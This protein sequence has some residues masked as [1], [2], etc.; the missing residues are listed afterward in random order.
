MTTVTS[1]LVAIALGLVACSKTEPPPPP[2]APAS[3]VASALDGKREHGMLNCPSGVEGS[4][5]QLQ[6]S[7][8]DVMLTITA[9]DVSARRKIVTLAHVQERAGNPHGGLIDNGQHGGPGS[10]GFCPIVHADTAV[11]VEEVRGGVIV[12]IRPNDPAKLEAL[13]TSIAAR[14]KALTA[15]AAS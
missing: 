15:G 3:P 12:H 8:T 5:T 4:T 11:T 9:A 13:K 2:P 6:M 7:P 1:S 14:V 10:S